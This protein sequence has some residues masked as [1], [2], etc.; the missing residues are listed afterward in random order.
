MV[1]TVQSALSQIEHSL[2]GSLSAELD[3]IGILNE[4]GQYMATMHDWMWL[5]RPPASLNF[6]GELSLSGTGWAT[7]SVG[8]HLQKTGAF[9]NYTHLVGDTIVVTAG[10]TGGTSLP[11]GRYQIREKVSDNAIHIEW[12]NTTNGSVTNLSATVKAD[13]VALP[14]DFANAIDIQPTEGLVNTFNFCDTAM[15]NQL[16]TNE[17]AVGNFRYWGAITRGLTL[18]N[19]AVT[20]NGKWRMEIYPSPSSNEAN[21]LT[22][23]YRAGWI[24]IENDTVVIPIPEFCNTLYRSLVR[25]FARGYE[26]DDIQ[27][28]HQRLLEIQQSP[29]FIHAKRR[30]GDMQPTLGQMQGGAVTQQERAINQYLK[31]SVLG[32]S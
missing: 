27:S 9:A 21:A 6:R 32:P 5:D 12:P 31:S 7:A 11:L 28:I 29:I 26:E 13:S 17:V 18:T 16:R 20:G 23:F 15:I 4:A 3:A 19:G 1:L 30:D 24:D 22:M 2:G 8:T 25:A 14:S 10:L